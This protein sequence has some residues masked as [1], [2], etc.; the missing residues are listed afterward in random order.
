[1]K[2]A[3]KKTIMWLILPHFTIMC[4]TL[5]PYTFFAFDQVNSFFLGNHIRSILHFKLLVSKNHCH[6]NIFKVSEIY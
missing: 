5:M 1:M 6:Q 3:L 4:L 2:R